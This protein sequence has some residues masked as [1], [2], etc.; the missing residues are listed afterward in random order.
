MPDHHVEADTLGALKHD[1][2]LHRQVPQ[3]PLRTVPQRGM[4]PEGRQR[5]I[6]QRHN[7]FHIL[8]VRTSHTPGA[9]TRAWM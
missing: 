3:V 4:V 6:G 1:M 5:L 2:A 8:Q 9:M 7:A